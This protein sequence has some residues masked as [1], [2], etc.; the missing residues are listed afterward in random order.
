MEHHVNNPFMPTMTNNEGVVVTKPD[1]SDDWEFHPSTN[2]NNKKI[3]RVFPITSHR[4]TTRSTNTRNH[5]HTG[6]C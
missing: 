5:V 4:S 2:N 1:V 6:F 3:E